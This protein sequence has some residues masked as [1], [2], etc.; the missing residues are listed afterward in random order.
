MEEDLAKLTVLGNYLVFFA[1][2]LFVLAAKTEARA[3]EIQDEECKKAAEYLAITLNLV[4]SWT[5][6]FGDYLLFKAAQ[7]D[8]ENNKNSGEPFDEYAGNLEVLV[9]G[10]QVALDVLSVQLAERAADVVR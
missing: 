1:D 4:G 3:E 6:L 5:Q 7:A 2:G 9:A 8:F 10:S